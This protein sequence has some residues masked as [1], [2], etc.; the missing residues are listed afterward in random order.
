MVTVYTFAYM[1]VCYSTRNAMY[2]KHYTFIVIII[3]NCAHNTHINAII[4][5]FYYNDKKT[6][7][8]LE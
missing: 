8:T 6:F 7:H 2:G 4:Y 3:Y 1:F 5:E